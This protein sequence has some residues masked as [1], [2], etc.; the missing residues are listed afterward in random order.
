M[1]ALPP[2][3]GHLQLIRFASNLANR[4]VVMLTTQP[5]EPFVKERVEAINAAISKMPWNGGSIVLKH[6]A[7]PM[8][9]NPD[10]EGF[11]SRWAGIMIGAG[12][13]PGDLLVISE[14]WGQ[15][16]AE[17]TGMDWRPYDIDRSING[18]KATEVRGYPSVYWNSI[19]PEF[20]RHLQT[21]VTIFG[22]ESTGKST[23]AR[24]LR[25]AHTEYPDD[26][27]DDDAIFPK[28]TV[29][30]EYARPYLEST[31]NEIT[32]RSMVAI[33]EGQRALQRADWSEH[34]LVV[35]DTDLF[36]TWGYWSYFAW[37]D[38][39][40][41]H[42]GTW[43]GEGRLPSVPPDQ[44]EQDAWDLRSDLYLVTPSDGVA[45]AADPLRYGG[46]HREIEDDVWINQLRARGLN[47]VV[48][49]RGS[50]SERLQEAVKLIKG[51]MDKKAESIAYDRH[52]Y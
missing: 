8:D 12:A 16:L 30:P 31:V 45:F 1:T 19:L 5:D 51:A 25:W 37:H 14:P 2:T 24:R 28:C 34:P 6:Y 21:R 27:S 38:N 3:T 44:L 9:P 29:L 26:G 42:V 33:W 43:V 35:Q 50:K 4:T 11:R 23:L 40:R 46:D 36:S 22:A 13:E 7:R 15:W 48:L 49:P 41:S 47:Y 20:R 18:V 52:G 17:L 39:N 10:S 32:T